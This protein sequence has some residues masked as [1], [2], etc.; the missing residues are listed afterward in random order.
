M[1][2]TIYS[3]PYNVFD[4]RMRS[5][6]VSLLF[7]YFKPQSMCELSFSIIFVLWIRLPNIWFGV[8]YFFTEHQDLHTFFFSVRIVCETK[9]SKAKKKFSQKKL[10]EALFWLSLSFERLFFLWFFIFCVSLKWTTT[11]R[12]ALS[13]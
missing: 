4:C 8:K 12:N 6:D 1:L 3:F 10:I 9:H 13:I 11:Q 2:Y 7:A 5:N